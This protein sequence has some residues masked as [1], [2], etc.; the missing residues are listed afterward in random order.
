LSANRARLADAQA[1][2]VEFGNDIASGE[3]ISARIIKTAIESAF[4][5][6]R[7]TALSIAGKV[8]DRVSAH[9]EQDRIAVHAIIDR[10]MREM[11][12]ALS[13]VDL[14]KATADDKDDDAKQ[15]DD[16]DGEEEP[17]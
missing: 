4:L 3:Y 7:E 12:T 16:N 13:T 9:T 5:N 6:I 8:S 10:E 15:E 1:R 14:H 2:K 11:L 17:A